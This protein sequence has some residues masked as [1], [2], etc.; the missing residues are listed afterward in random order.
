MLLLALA[1]RVSSAYIG[2]SNAWD[3]S[4]LCRELSDG[5]V[6][7]T[8]TFAHLTRLQL[9]AQCQVNDVLGFFC[10]DVSTVEGFLAA[11][12]NLKTFEL[13]N[14]VVISGP[15]EIVP[16]QLT[17]L[18]LINS[19]LSARSLCQIFRT[20]P[21]LKKISMNYEEF[22]PRWVPPQ[23]DTVGLPWPTDIA[24]A[25][26]PL[27][28]TLEKLNLDCRIYDNFVEHLDVYGYT[29]LPPYDTAVIT[30]PGLLIRALTGFP[31][32]TVLGINSAIIDHGCQDGLVDLIKGCE[33]LRILV[34]HDASTIPREALLR[35]ARA[36]SELGF[37]SLRK[38]TLVSTCRMG[39]GISLIRRPNPG[40]QTFITY[41]E[42]VEK[43]E[44]Q[45]WDRL[46]RITRSPVR[47]L[48]DTGNVEM[49][50]DKGTPVDSARARHFAKA[51]EAGRA[52]SGRA[53]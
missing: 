40:Q 4:F 27:G 25:L 46:R 7:P 30:P 5:T 1:S 14:M 53:H 6:G 23:G 13:R 47:E 20:C 18:T 48:F 32:L 41:A 9:I 38:V 33:N 51:E 34:V 10:Y 52:Y 35:F 24:G 21:R 37:P 16:P 31:A 50:L 39:L 28:Q 45:M 44:K 49:V 2:V 36:V 11:A 12:P 29:S 26:A 43:Y 3:T 19:R 42:A 8:A 22:R 17:S 15:L